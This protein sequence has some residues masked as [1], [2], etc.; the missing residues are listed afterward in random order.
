MVSLKTTIGLVGIGGCLLFACLMSY[1]FIELLTNIL[2][3][4]I[5]SIIIAFFY[6]NREQALSIIYFLL[7]IEYHDN[8]SSSSSSSS[9]LSQFNNAESSSSP[10]TIK[11]TTT[12]NGQKSDKEIM[13]QLYDQI[14][15]LNLSFFNEK[16]S[17][18]RDKINLSNKIKVLEQNIT[19]T[20]AERNKLR[21]DLQQS[22]KRVTE[23]TKE[24][25]SVS[26]N[27]Q[28]LLLKLS[29][30][31]KR[32]RVNQE[33]EKVLQK[34]I[35]ELKDNSNSLRKDSDEKSKRIVKLEDQ[36]AKFTR[37]LPVTPVTSNIGIN[38]NTASTA[39]ISSSPSSNIPITQQTATTTQHLHI[40]VLQGTTSSSSPIPSPGTSPSSYQFIHPSSSDDEGTGSSY[41]NYSGNSSDSP[42]PFKSLMKK[43][44]NGSSKIINKAQN[45]LNKH[46]N[47]DFFTPPPNGTGH[48]ANMPPSLQT[49]FTNSPQKQ[50][51]DVQKV[52]I[53]SSDNSSHE[54]A[55]SLS[56]M[57]EQANSKK[58]DTSSLPDIFTFEDEPNGGLNLKHDLDSSLSD[59]LQLDSN[60]LKITLTSFVDRSQDT[61]KLSTTLQQTCIKEFSVKESENKAG[62]RRAKKKPLSGMPGQNMMEDVSFASHPF[63]DNPEMA[64]FGVFDGHAGREA[65]DQ[66]CTLLPLQVTKY[67][68]QQK[69]ENPQ[70]DPESSTDMSDMLNAAFASVDDLMKQDED[71]Q[72]VG[73]TAT[74]A[75]IWSPTNSSSNGEECKY[76]QVA[77][78]G[79]SSAYLCRNGKAVAMTF[80]HKANDPLEKK[81]MIDSGIPVSDNQT[82]IN[83]IAVSRSLG[84]HF[85]KDQNIGMIGIP[86][87]SQPIKLLPTDSFLIIASDG[88]W[89]VI[90]GEQ[91]C[92]I[93]QDLIES[94]GAQSVASTLLQNALQI[95]KSSLQIEMRMMMTIMKII[96]FVVTIYILTVDANS[97]RVPS[98]YD[99]MN[100]L[101]DID[102]QSKEILQG[103]SASGEG[104][105]GIDI[106]LSKQQQLDNIRAK[107]T[108]SHLQ[109]TDNDLVGS[110]SYQPWPGESCN[111][112][113]FVFN[114]TASQCGL[115]D[116]HSAWDQGT[117]I[118][119][120]NSYVCACNPLY[121]GPN[122][123]FNLNPDHN[124]DLM[125]CH[126]GRFCPP[127]YGVPGLYRQCYCPPGTGGIE[128]SVC[129]NDSYCKASN[130]S[131]I[132]DQSIYIDHHKAY[133]CYVTSPEVN[134]DL[135]NS[136]ASTSL[137]CDFPTADYTSGEGVCSMNLYYRLTGDPLYFNCTFTNCTREI[138]PGQGQEIYCSTSMCNCTT[139]CGAI[140]NGLVSAVT[141]YAKFSCDTTLACVFSQEVFLAMLPAI[142]LQC[143]AGECDYSPPIIYPVPVLYTK[144][145]LMCLGAGGGVVGFAILLGLISWV[146]VKQEERKKPAEDV[147]ISCELRFDDVSCIVN[148]RKVF[149]LFSGGG[150][151]TGN[152]VILNNVSGI[153]YPGQL[154][155]L[156]GLSGSG[157]TSLLDILSGRKN[158]GDITG[159][160]LINGY[161]RLK[162]FKRIS[163]Y[164][165]QEDIMIGT[166]TCREHLNYTA[167]L[168]LPEGMP[169][170][171]KMARVN[172]VLTEL[173]LMHICENRI[174][175][176]EKRGISG[177]ERRRL[178]IAAEL[179][180]DPSILFLDEPTSG[181]DSHS[182]S[183]LIY[184]LK[185]LAKNR[186]R[187][188][189]FSI[190]QP[191][192]EIFEQFDNLILLHKGNPYYSGKASEAVPFFQEQ[193]SK[194]DEHQRFLMRVNPADF[195]ISALNDN[196]V[197]P[198]FQLN[199]PNKPDIR[200]DQPKEESYNGLN[201]NGD[202]NN[203]EA[204]Q[205]DL[206]GESHLLNHVGEPPRRHH[207]LEDQKM[208]NVEEYATSFWTQFFVVSHRSLLNY[209]RNPFLLR[210]TYFV[211]ITV[212]LILGYLFWQLPSNLEPGAQN[213]FGSMF[214]MIALLSF[215]SITSLDLF[216]HDR[217]IFIRERANGY[218]RTSSYFLAKVLTD[219]IPMRVI[220]PIILGSICYYMIGFRSGINH[221]IYFLISLVLT[222]S[223]AS[224]MCM[225]ISTI[226]PTF[227]TAN[228]LS[229]LLLFV[230][231]LFDGFL[232]ARQ[233]IPKYLVWL[234]WMSFMSYGLEIPV[235][236]EFAG[237]WIFYNP[238]NTQGTYADGLEFL[239]TIG[240]D[241]KRLFL[242]MYVLCGMIGGYL[243]LAYLSLRFFVREF[244]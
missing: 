15:E 118:A 224:S 34:K 146:Y 18:D 59:L 142:P 107:W 138:L 184:S 119:N 207:L 17:H 132:C 83:G 159:E 154:T 128:C 7:N 49:I 181:L 88:L 117:C 162:N 191:S 105:E 65:A 210:T 197:K 115:Q 23:L 174:G 219:L 223:T 96:I 64:L 185:Q 125:D 201:A 135:Q 236:N 81:R 104:L 192:A 198:C 195:I 216:Y 106:F 39:A 91:A 25:D 86:H 12:N 183:E 151:A 44:K 194:D 221:F 204:I 52:V 33:N 43:V 172:S 103:S 71:M 74:V 187:T 170:A 70:Y 233:S 85:I 148:E 189:I 21:D 29:D 145:I 32:D 109:N 147:H 61:V 244:R 16:L 164:V 237:S 220:P 153:C 20:S 152:K 165:T 63:N 110:T 139:Y 171:Q 232:L 120:G 53:T 243:L 76:L 218:Y 242:D 89:D 6:Q 140:L 203:D 234:V 75:F 196:V 92:E 228:M 8:K 69:I 80:D 124:W 238:P 144:F 22:K 134:G 127:V 100:H 19:D 129:T 123:E 95:Y 11:A 84:N 226:S 55:T 30:Y 225:A 57:I 157:K 111:A 126:G 73:C 178:S 13:V 54:E 87:L 177:G 47:T 206:E 48:P 116:C 90:S 180:V 175:T 38:G 28:K 173:N 46:L 182:A 215:G 79:D 24:K 60:D 108:P 199:Y 66:A 163:G 37:P 133:S 166:L 5:L 40:P 217:I 149:S 150:G 56:I 160:V 121:Y 67:I 186:N 94:R 9:K 168:K 10:T 42:K 130:S 190:H 167:M 114:N 241:P 205:S 2:Y 176:P 41:S 200:V 188:I 4:V 50:Q 211:H 99:D 112:T 212:G 101:L 209:I 51:I 227:G 141:G 222:S 35:S 214:F 68:E 193:R 158:V 122:C 72:Y 113:S 208:I 102:Q 155:A 97:L 156:M 93:G 98:K 240:A 36:L 136:T 235:V 82:R 161:P 169:K 179:L 143:I 239:E 3:T 58:I 137:D 26:N 62:L 45:Q 230:F 231:L 1:E 131:T 229:I 202:I 27:E 213:R 14:R 31:E 78:V 77:N